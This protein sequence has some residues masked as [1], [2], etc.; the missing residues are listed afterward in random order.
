MSS[1][2]RF[3]GI[4]DMPGIEF[5]VRTRAGTQI[6]AAEFY[7]RAS[8]NHL[9]KAS[10]NLVDRVRRNV[11]WFNGKLIILKLNRAKLAKN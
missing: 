11:D 5:N 2:G 1:V 7:S 6:D 3:N 8:M 4:A 9:E 10:G